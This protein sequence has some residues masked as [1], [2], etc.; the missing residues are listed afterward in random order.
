MSSAIAR[1]SYVG[2]GLATAEEDCFLEPALKSMAEA[3][4]K[5]VGPGPS[6]AWCQWKPANDKHGQT[7][8]AHWILAAR[9]SFSTCT[10]LLA[11]NIGMPSED[12]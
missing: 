6:Q 7:S 2:L 10:S 9:C 4:G 1:K 3:H 11:S 8:T 5:T 12:R